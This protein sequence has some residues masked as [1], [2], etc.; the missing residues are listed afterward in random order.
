[1]DFYRLELNVAN[2]RLGKLGSGLRNVDSWD[3][4]LGNDSPSPPLRCIDES[5]DGRQD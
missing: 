2:Q 4:V 3:T 5:A 1:L